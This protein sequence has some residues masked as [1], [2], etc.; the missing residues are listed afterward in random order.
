MK[1][2][3]IWFDLNDEAAA[4][5]DV[6][7]IG[8]PYD[9]SASRRAGA[10]QAPARLRELSKTSDSI[11]RRGTLIRNLSVRDFGDV[12]PGETESQR[13]YLDRCAARLSELP[14]DATILALGGDNSISIPSLEDFVARHGSD[15]GVIW[16]DAHPDLFES[17]DGNV[18]S[19]ACALRRAMSRAGL[20]PDRIALLGTR[21]FSKEESRFIA[22]A[23]IDVVTAAAWR[24]GAAE[25][26][27]SRLAAR[28]EGAHAVYLAVDIDGFDASCAPGTGYPMPGG[29]GAEEF[30]CLLEQLI[31]RLP[32]RAIDLT[33]IAP[34][35]D[36]NDVK[37]FLGVQVVLEALGAMAARRSSSG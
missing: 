21:S 4:S 10:A 14:G 26:I 5:P 11:T 6:A 13:D 18:D 20:S 23:G 3:R 33:E 19:H 22:E 1:E 24:A 12:T 25:S 28:L 36:T 8:M 2:R 27:A 17:Y 7:I 35:L 32:I 16:F 31:G 15:A 9:G 30:F 29:V 37:G 34:P